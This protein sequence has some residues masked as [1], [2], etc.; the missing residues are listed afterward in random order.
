ME[1]IGKSKNSGRIY[2]VI[3]EIPIGRYSFREVVLIV[4]ASRERVGRDEDDLVEFASESPQLGVD[5]N[6]FGIKVSGVSEGDVKELFG[7]HFLRELAR[8][9]KRG[10]F[11]TAR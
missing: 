3:G 9:H 11:M 4:R 2:F 7:S 10:E 8:F 6:L 1:Y 5:K